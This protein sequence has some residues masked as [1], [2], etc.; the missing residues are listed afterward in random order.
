MTQS[1]DDLL[2][3][4]DV[5]GAFALLKERVRANPA[6]AGE[7]VFLFQLLCV[8]GDWERALTQLNTAGELDP[9]TL[10]MVQ[11]YREVLQAEALRAS[12]FRGERAPLVFGEPE[13]WL[14]LLLHS[15]QLAAEGKY[16]QADAI[17]DEAFETAPTTS[18]TINGEPFEWIADADTRLG[19]CLEVIVEGRYNW[20]PFSRLKSVEIEEPTDLRDLVWLPAT[21]TFSNGGQVVAFIPTRYP[22][23]EAC[24]DGAI[25]L[26]RRTDWTNYS[27]GTVAGIGQ[28][29]LVTDV[30]E[31]PLLELRRL[32]LNT[33]PEATESS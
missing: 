7:R 5:P 24:E 23:S 3:G 26:A 22:G 10:L 19:P 11:A 20:L 9:G 29:M 33:A 28:R 18:G 32:E 12:V 17:R 4:G 14:G 6:A 27:E 15:A 1:A 16:D 30:G 25:R 13:H 21:L 8:L 31:Y 2:K